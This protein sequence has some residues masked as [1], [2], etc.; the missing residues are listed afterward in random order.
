MNLSGGGEELW[1]HA[2]GG[3]EKVAATGVFECIQN[4]RIRE[5]EIGYTKSPSLRVQQDRLFLLP[6]M[7]HILNCC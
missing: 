6:L 1:K 7:E 2:I 4:R 3:E 5:G